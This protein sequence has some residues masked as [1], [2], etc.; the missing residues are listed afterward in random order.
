MKA[1]EINIDAKPIPRQGFLFE[2]WTEK[3][4]M[5]DP[6]PEVHYDDEWFD[7]ILAE[8]A[9]HPVTGRPQVGLDFEFS[10]KNYKP[11]IVGIS[12]V[13]HCVGLRWNI[14]QGL[15]LEA[16]IE[17]GTELVAYSTASADKHVLDR[18]LGRITPLSG[19]GDGMLTHYLK[20]QDFCKTPA[21]GED[22]S[23]AGVMGFMN[24]WTATSCVSPV[25]QW[26]ICRGRV[27]DGPCP[28]HDV[29]G[30]CA[31]DAWGG[32]MAEQKNMP[33]IVKNGGSVAFYRE[34]LETTD[35]TW[36]MQERG[37][38]VDIPYVREMDE[39]MGA[40]KMLLFPHKLDEFG[41]ETS[42]WA[43]F[44]PNSPQQGLEY[45]RKRGIV[46]ASGNKADVQKA[47]IKHAKRRGFIAADPKKQLAGIDAWE[48]ES[49]MT[50][51]LAWFNYKS[52][53][54]GLSPWFKDSGPRKNVWEES[55]GIWIVH[56]RF[57]VPATS[58][59]RLGSSGPNLQNIP[60]RGW[61]ELVRQAI[62]PRDK[63]HV[64]LKSDYGQLELRMCLYL[65]GVDPRDIKG[66]AFNWLISQDEKSFVSAS[67]LI[68]NGVGPRDVAKSVSH[69]GDYLEGFMVLSE[70]D[71]GKPY[72]LRMIDSGALRVYLKKFGA[73]FDWYFGG[74]VVAFSGANLAERMFGSKSHENRRKALQI[75]EDVYFKNFPMLRILQRDE[76]AKAEE[77]GYVLSRTG[78]FL[79]LHGT[80]EDNAKIIMAFHGQG[81]SAD[82]VQ[83]VMRRYWRAHGSGD[84]YAL[85]RMQVHDELDWDIPRKWADNKIVDHVTPMMEES[86]LLPGFICP[87]TAKV[88]EN[89]NENRMRKVHKGG[90]F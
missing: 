53:G 87:I 15:K 78:R 33:T 9:E 6:G 11:T 20:N 2:G 56:A 40:K 88:G 49:P 57:I 44:N 4:R 45:F 71:L 3:R 43:W 39:N 61:G 7:R 80:P 83:E 17:A 30:Y 16:A 89:W 35:M 21:K 85:P 60:A 51:L 19:W 50:E 41:R 28:R 27:C 12:N 75:Q 54:K 81:T 37:V 55:P 74:G 22:E 67:D 52:E 62:I 72:Y 5:Y 73:P 25:P 70:D 86:K 1:S 84:K 79:E 66:D 63:H 65:A 32:L 34:L 82:F 90:L 59:G 18:E 76:L 42:E 68:G 26:K 46:I 8:P 58:T 10:T 31:M 69:A 48:W 64:F 29:F 36:A 24:L 77:R 13:D 23:D 47:L 14:E 38:R